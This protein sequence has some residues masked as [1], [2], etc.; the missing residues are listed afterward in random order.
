[1]TII[2]KNTVLLFSEPFRS[3]F[4]SKGNLITNHPGSPCLGLSLPCNEVPEFLLTSN[5]PVVRVVSKLWSVYR[6]L[7]DFSQSTYLVTFVS[8][9]L[10]VIPGSGQ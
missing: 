3:S 10:T 8:V 7:V 2:I 1:M 5:R 4:N 9:T 6:T